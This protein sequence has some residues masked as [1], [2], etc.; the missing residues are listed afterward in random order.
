M[1]PLLPTSENPIDVPI[2][3]DP[4]IFHILV[5]WISDNLYFPI[6]SQMAHIPNFI[7]AKALQVLA[8]QLMSV[9][10]WNDFFNQTGY[11]KSIL[12]SQ[13]IFQLT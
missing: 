6:F 7:W 8:I 1:I 3:A 12:F 4:L 2:S 13:I 9:E 5:N 11:I 10:I